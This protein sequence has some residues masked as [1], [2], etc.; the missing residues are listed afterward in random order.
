MATAGESKP[1]G[2]ASKW[3]LGANRRA[4]P[5]KMRIHAQQGSGRDDTAPRAFSPTCCQVV[6][7]AS[8]VQEWARITS[9]VPFS[10]GPRARR[11][12]WPTELLTVLLQPPPS[13]LFH[14]LRPS[15]CPTQLGQVS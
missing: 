13:L 15:P 7:S 8:A 2:K 4:V 11:A 5:S 6:R 1:A 9:I 10:S 14:S 12:S 3:Q